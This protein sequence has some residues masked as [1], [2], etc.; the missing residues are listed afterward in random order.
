MKRQTAEHR[1]TRG[2][3]ETL[4]EGFSEMVMWIVRKRFYHN[5]GFAAR[6]TGRSVRD[7]GE[8]LWTINRK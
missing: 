8:K 4:H 2:Q 6:T 3:V 1:K 7:G 5:P